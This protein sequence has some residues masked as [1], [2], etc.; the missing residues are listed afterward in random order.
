VELRRPFAGEVDLPEGGS[1]EHRSREGQ[2]IAQSD[3]WM[4]VVA[5]P[6]G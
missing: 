3:C 4:H 2:G 5:P 1:G 6:T